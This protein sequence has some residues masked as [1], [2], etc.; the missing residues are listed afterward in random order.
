[1]LPDI[2]NVVIIDIIYLSQNSVILLGM[3]P[4]SE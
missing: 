1:M 2:D 4:V 3:P